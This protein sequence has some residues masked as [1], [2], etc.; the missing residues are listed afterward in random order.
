MLTASSVKKIPLSVLAL[1]CPHF[2]PYVPKRKKNAMKV[3]LGKLE[4]EKKKS[5]LGFRDKSEQASDLVSN[6]PGHYPDQV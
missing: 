1:V 6:L 5:C 2:V 4:R 3:L